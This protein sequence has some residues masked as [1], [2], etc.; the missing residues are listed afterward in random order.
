MRVRS[1]A[2]RPW[3]SASPSPASTSSSSRRSPSAPVQSS[4]DTLRLILVAAPQGSRPG[5]PPCSAGGRAA[6]PCC[7]LRRVGEAAQAIAEGELDTR[8]ESR[9][10]VTSRC[11]RPRSTTWRAPSRPASSATPG[12]RRGQPRAAFP[13]HDADG[14]GRRARGAT[15]R[16][17]G[18]GPHRT[19]PAVHDLDRFQPSSRTCSRSRVSTPGR[20]DSTC[21]RCASSS[22][23][24]RR[25][26][27]DQ[28]R[29][30]PHAPSA[31][32]RVGR[33]PRRQAPHGAGDREPRR[34]RPEVRGRA[35]GDRD[36]RVP[37]RTV[38]IAV[39]DEGPGVPP[40][41]R[42]VVFD[43]FSRG[44]AGGRRGDDT[45]TGLGPGARRRARAS[46]RRACLDRPPRWL[47]GGA[48]RHRTAPLG[49][50]SDYE[51]F[52]PLVNDPA[53][54]TAESNR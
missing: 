30:R 52:R 51:D 10:T 46:A 4:L 45:G 19:R 18:A 40:E 2:N 15:R 33:R 14:V 13:A 26:G 28:S 35:H 43:R 23:C 29:G 1:A 44:S 24:A 37:R 39:E 50:R 12:S 54:V 5:S 11:S 38:E 47:P 20:P 53:V 32:G 8:L 9:P 27:D 36:P 48:L 17:A 41:E 49:H 3:S 22:S 21:P 7:P 42:E 6:A 34:Q 16:D 25:C 31:R